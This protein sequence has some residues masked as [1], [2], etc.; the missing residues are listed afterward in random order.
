MAASL[1]YLD[2]IVLCIVGFSTLIGFFRGFIASSMSMAGWVLSLCLT[3]SLFPQVAPYLENRLS[4]PIAVVVVGYMG[5]IM[6]LLIF[7]G[8]VNTI[9][10]SA[11]SS[12]RQGI[13][14]RSLGAGL[15]IF[16]GFFIMAVVFLSLTVVINLLQGHDDI[17]DDSN[18][19][20]KWLTEAQAYHTLVQS[21]NTLVSVLPNSFNF[22]IQQFYDQY[23]NSKSSDER[24][25]TY[26]S[27]KL[28]D[29]LPQ[30]ALNSI[31]KDKAEKALVMSEK[32]LEVYN[33]QCIVRAYEEHFSSSKYPLS[34]VDMKRVKAL[35]KT[36]QS[37]E[38]SKLSTFGEIE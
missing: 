12:M 21:K 15:G 17:T 4:H 28:A 2:I 24:F 23:L 26:A 13:I 34:D 32:D 11:T 10:C 6:T 20:H 9:F 33:L 3:Y 29:K 31:E 5:L 38:V 36:Q 16:R 7:F 25:I 1:A 35:L 14:D 37:A 27:D 18:I 8:V 19:N 22:G 30:S